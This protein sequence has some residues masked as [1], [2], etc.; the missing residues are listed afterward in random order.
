MFLEP[1]RQRGGAHAVAVVGVEDERQ[2][3]ALDDPLL[4]KCLG[5]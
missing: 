1:A 2:L 4:Q 3:A 5:H